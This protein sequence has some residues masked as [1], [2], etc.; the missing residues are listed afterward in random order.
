MMKIYVYAGVKLYD[1][2]CVHWCACTILWAGR[3]GGG[4]DIGLRHLNPGVGALGDVVVTPAKQRELSRNIIMSHA[5]GVG[6]PLPVPVGS[7]PWRTKPG[8]T[9]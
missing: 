5:V 4:A 8:I 3:D 1:C 9:R 2:V 7:P 6:P